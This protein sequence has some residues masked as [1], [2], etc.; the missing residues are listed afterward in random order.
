LETGLFA[1]GLTWPKDKGMRLDL[2]LSSKVSDR[3]VD[4]GVDRWVRGQVNASDHA[5]AWRVLDL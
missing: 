2:L 5:P 4:G 1:K 3:L